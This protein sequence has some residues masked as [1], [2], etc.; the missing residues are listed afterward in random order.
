[1]QKSHCHIFNDLVRAAFGFPR[2]SSEFSEFLILFFRSRGENEMVGKKY[3]EIVQGSWLALALLHGNMLYFIWLVVEEYLN[4]YYKW[5]LEITIL[6]LA[7]YFALLNIVCF[8]AV[9][10]HV[11]Y[12]CS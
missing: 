12:S 1:M 4:C 5:F 9:Y 3:V 8:Q 10:L 7:R 11:M 2:R 6:N